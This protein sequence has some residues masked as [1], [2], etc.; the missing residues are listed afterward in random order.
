MEVN[1]EPSESTK[2]IITISLSV[3]GEREQKV[4]GERVPVMRRCSLCR[5]D[6]CGT[7]KGAD[8]CKHSSEKQPGESRNACSSVWLGVYMEGRRWQG[9]VR[10]DASRQCGESP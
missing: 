8:K 6:Q 10:N 4:I 5:P 9:T 2:G 7:G 1:K 3:K